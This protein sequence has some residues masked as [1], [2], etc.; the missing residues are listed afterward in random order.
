MSL[1]ASEKYNIF[2]QYDIKAK[3]NLYCVSIGNSEDV[4]GIFPT[5]EEAKEF[6]D[7]KNNRLEKLY[8]NTAP[9]AKPKRRF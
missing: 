1:R 2:T 7:M 9:L 6:A 3:K 8:R 5:R 4:I